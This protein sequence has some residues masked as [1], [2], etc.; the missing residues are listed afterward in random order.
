MKILILEDAEYRISSFKRMFIGHDWNL[1]GEPK[2]AINFLQSDE[3]DM[4]FLDHDLYGQ[5]HVP[6]GEDT[7]W[8]VCKFLADNPQHMPKQV[9][10]HSHNAKGVEE[11]KKLLPNAEVKSFGYFTFDGE[12]LQDSPEKIII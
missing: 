5:I 7:G 3:W 10:L 11:M 6:S 9:I 12:K 4:L 1:T 8:E 2:T